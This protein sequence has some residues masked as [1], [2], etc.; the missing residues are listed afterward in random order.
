M[1]LSLPVTRKDPNISIGMAIEPIIVGLLGS[2]LIDSIGIMGVMKVFSE[3]FTI[4]DISPIIELICVIPFVLFWGGGCLI[5]IIGGFG[6]LIKRKKWF[7]QSQITQCT[8]IDKKLI[9]FYDEYGGSYIYKVKML[10]KIEHPLFEQFHSKPI[11]MR[12]SEKIYFKYKKGD[13]GKI[14]FSTKEPLEFLIYGE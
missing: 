11:E 4:E 5:A 12:V 14:F 7:K 6:I 8:I 13:R 2:I 1:D 3:K 9:D 10:V